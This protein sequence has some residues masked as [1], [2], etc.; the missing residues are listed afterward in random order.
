[1]GSRN[2]HGSGEDAPCGPI[3]HG[4]LDIHLKGE[5]NGSE[6]LRANVDEGH[7]QK[8][9]E[10]IQRGGA[11]NERKSEVEK[12]HIAGNGEN[13]IVN[14][15]PENNCRGRSRKRARKAPPEF[16]VTREVTFKGLGGGGVEEG[17]CG[18]PN[19]V[20]ARGTQ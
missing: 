20:K 16:L 2:G 9:L 8:T 19:L 3:P 4:A 12:S 10:G 13:I 7:S 1:M 17:E 11:S 14:F 18:G 6:R 5:K 15:T